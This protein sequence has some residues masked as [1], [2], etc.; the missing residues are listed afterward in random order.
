VDLVTGPGG[1]PGAR[2][3]LEDNA[4]VLLRR[5][6][7]TAARRAMAAAARLDPDDPGAAYSHPLFQAIAERAI[8]SILGPEGMRQTRRQVPG[9][10]DP[11]EQETPPEPDEPGLRRRPSGLILPG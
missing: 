11:G 6:E 4:L 2:R 3:R 1:V 9:V 8:E 5:G 10:S 7:S